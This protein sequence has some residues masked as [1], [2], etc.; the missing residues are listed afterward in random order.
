MFQI[1]R[2]CGVTGSVCHKT[3]IRNTVEPGIQTD[4]PGSNRRTARAEAR[5]LGLSVI[6]IALYVVTWQLEGAMF[7][8]GNVVEWIHGAPQSPASAYREWA[9]YTTTTLLIFWAYGALISMSL[10]GELDSGRARSYALLA[11]ILLN[12]ML[13]FQAAYTGPVLLIAA[14]R[15]AE[16]DRLLMEHE[17]LEIDMQQTLLNENTKLTR[18]I[19]QLTTEVHAW[20]QKAD[21][22]APD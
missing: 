14:N 11:P 22:R 9:A 12:L 16:R 15:S 5:V 3:Q 4:V 20:I 1:M 13:S 8:G 6:T 17:A 18:Q 7:R 19:H 21:A 2:Q 10:R